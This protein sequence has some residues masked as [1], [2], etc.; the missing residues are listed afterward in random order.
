MPHN[1]PKVEAHASN[2]SAIS[3]YCRF[4]QVVLSLLPMEGFDAD[5]DLGVKQGKVVSLMDYI[6][7]LSSMLIV[8]YGTVS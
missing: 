5:F 8:H 4:A 1:M 2:E 6:S 3:N 7:S